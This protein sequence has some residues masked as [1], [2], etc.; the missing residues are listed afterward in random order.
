[1]RRPLLLQFSTSFVRMVSMRQ[2]SV[3]WR[4]EQGFLYVSSTVSPCAQLPVAQGSAAAF[5]LVE[6]STLIPTIKPARGRPSPPPFPNGTRAARPA[7][8]VSGRRVLLVRRLTARSR[9]RSP[10]LMGRGA[11]RMRWIGLLFPGAHSD[12]CRSPCSRLFK[13]FDFCGRPCFRGSL[14][15]GRHRENDN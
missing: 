5:Q 8:R 13:I 11:V 15:L 6:R 3:A 1:M 2:L 12:R 7:A 4:K 10:V 14:V 9:S